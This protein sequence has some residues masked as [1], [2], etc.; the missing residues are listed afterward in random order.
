MTCVD[1]FE[2]HA[3]LD[4]TFARE[5]SITVERLWEAL[6]DP[7]ILRRW[8]LAAPYE[9]LECE[10]DVRPG[11]AFHT[12]VRAPDGRRFDRTECFL[13]VMEPTRL[14]WTSVLA[15]GFRPNPETLAYTTT[16]VLAGTDA[17]SRFTAVALHADAATCDRH[18]EMGF[19]SGW[20]A[21]L[22]QLLETQR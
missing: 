10:V 12:V 18:R 11:G 4:L 1:G 16:I 6:T 7:E 22:D 8:F 3:G 19:D 17:G 15:G 5:M 9:L 13:E 21:A 20:D 2:S 14:V